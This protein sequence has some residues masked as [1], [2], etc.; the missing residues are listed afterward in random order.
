[1]GSYLN[2]SC[3]SFHQILNNRIYVDKTALLNILNAS[4]SSDDAFI[5][6]SRPRRFGKSTTAKMIC[7]Y[8]GE[9][10]DASALFAGLSIAAPHHTESILIITTRFS[11]TSA[12][13]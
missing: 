13:S 11:S 5:C 7:A 6:D 1:M 2:T 9:D 3:Y 12:M 10:Q 4:L 8:Y